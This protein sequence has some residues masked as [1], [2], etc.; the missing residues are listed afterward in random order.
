MIDEIWEMVFDLI[1]KRLLFEAKSY[2]DST[3][4]KSEVEDIIE[5]IEELADTIERDIKYEERR[6][7]WLKE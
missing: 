5:R 2:K 6:E 4:H 3:I 1:D 7:S